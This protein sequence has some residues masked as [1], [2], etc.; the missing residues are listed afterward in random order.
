MILGL[1]AFAVYGAITQ[2]T[3]PPLAKPAGSA[4]LPPLWKPEPRL[5]LTLPLTQT[6]Q[7][8]VERIS[9]AWES[10]K[11]ELLA[12]IEPLAVKLQSGDRASLGTLQANADG[13]AQISRRFDSEREARWQEALQLLT[14]SQR[15]QV[16]KLKEAQR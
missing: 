10:R 14:P 4:P 8:G 3:A 12:Q 13:Y 9:R 5:L 6:Q 16:A 15:G 2:P 7:A 11:K 1:V